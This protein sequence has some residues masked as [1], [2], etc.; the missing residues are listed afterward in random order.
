MGL[1]RAGGF[2]TVAFCE[3][4]KHAQ[5][6]LRRHW[7]DT[8]IFEDVNKLTKRHDMLEYGDGP[9]KI[10]KLGTSQIDIITAGFP[11]QDVSTANIK[12][13]GIQGERSG[14]W[15]EVKRLIKEISP[16]YALLENVANLRSRGLATVIKDLWEIGYDCEWHI[17]PACRVGAF[18][19]RE[20]I[21]IIAYPKN[22]SA[23]L[24]EQGVRGQLNGSSVQET[25]DTM[26][27]V[28]ESIKDR[29]LPNTDH[30][31]LWRPF[32]TKKEKQ[33][34]WTKRSSGFRDVFLKGFQVKPFIR[35]E[36]HGLSRSLDSNRRQRIKQLG[37]TVIPQIPQLIGEAILEYENRSKK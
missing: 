9:V 10:G 33:E 23:R 21:W 3:I 4:D 8:P 14:L 24:N 37:N 17:I 7:P 18:H 27:E 32:A 30:L 19:R 29:A 6:V 13:K 1:E 25:G 35:R 12:G 11:C 22:N 20:R 2:E 16:E 28:S 15:K 26:Q 34:W 31:R 36:V 5:K